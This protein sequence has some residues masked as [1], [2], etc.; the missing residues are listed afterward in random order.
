MGASNG[1][2]AF[3]LNTSSYDL[4]QVVKDLFGNDFEQSDAHCDSRKNDCVY[5]GKTQEFFIIV[6]TDFAEKFFESTDTKIIQPF[7]EYFSN[8]DFVFAFEEYDSGDTFS[9]SLV[10]G[11][12]VKRQFR[13]LSSNITIDYGTLEPLE[14]KWKNSE[15]DKEN[16]DGE[17][18]RMFIDSTRDFS[19]TEDQLPQVILQDLMYEKLGFA[20]W[21]MDEFIIEQ[22][23]F[24]KTLIMRTEKQNKT[25]VEE[26]GTKPWWKL[27]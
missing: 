2:V 1:G 14:L 27:W 7:L 8:P 13:S 20:S 12:N 10:Y 21:N 24:K 16:G 22:G 26:R 18:E 5:I 3:K 19:C 25:I 17:V 15:T 23:H 6:N 4:L 11:G 9:Y